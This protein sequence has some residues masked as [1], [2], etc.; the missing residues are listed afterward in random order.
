MPGKVREPIWDNLKG[1]CVLF[2]VILHTTMIWCGADMMMDG[3]IFG[4]LITALVF[5]V[6]PGFSFASGHLSSAEVSRRKLVS[7]ARMWTVFFVQQLIWVAFATGLSHLSKSAGGA[8]VP[9]LP[10]NFW[11][12]LGVTWFLFDLAIWRTVLPMIALL[13]WPVTLSVVVSC[14]APL[15]DASGNGFVQTAFCFLP[16]FVAGYK[17]SPEALQ[18]LRTPMVQAMFSAVLAISAVASLALPLIPG[19]SGAFD[20]GSKQIWEAYSCFYMIAKTDSP[21]SCHRLISPI[22]NVVFF[23]VGL[24]LIVGFL[25]CVPR[26][27]VWGLTRAGAFSLYIYLLH[28]YLVMISAVVLPI[29]RG[30]S[31]SGTDETKKGLLPGPYAFP[32]SLLFALFVWGCL[33]CGWPR[34]CCSLCMEPPIEKCLLHE[35]PEQTST[36]SP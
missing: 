31:S 2:V 30:T 10:F 25:S 7:L 17:C 18:R 19:T 3:K 27:K 32:L 33:G 15:T 13:R 8:R 11:G 29:V 34:L 1:L 24:P 20:F 9:W 14:L 28:F 21:D 22:T 6:M 12:V 36:C 4:G 35:D 16:F 5:V 26:H 23:A